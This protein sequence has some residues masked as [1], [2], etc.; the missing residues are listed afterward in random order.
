MLEEVKEALVAEVQKAENLAEKVEAAVVATIE[1]AE[2]AVVGAVESTEQVAVSTTEADVVKIE[3]DAK[4]VTADAKVEADRLTQ[5]AINAAAG[6]VISGVIETEAV[7]DEVK[8]RI[9]HIEHPAPPAP[10]ALPP[11]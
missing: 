1:H 11:W 8:D 6:A 5:E 4:I 9:G 2:A 10:G 3:T 7:L